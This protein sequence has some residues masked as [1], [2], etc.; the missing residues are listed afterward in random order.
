MQMNLL[1]TILEHR[2]SGRRVV[3]AGTDPGIVTT[4]TTIP[5]TLEEVFADINR[6]QVLSAEDNS[7]PET[8]PYPFDVKRLPKPS[9]ITAG[10]IDNA[11]FKKCHQK[12]HQR[13][14]ASGVSAE[15][16][17]K[18]L[19]KERREREIRA[20]R[21]YGK[22]TAQERRRIREHAQLPP[23]EQAPAVIH[24]FGHWQGV[25]SPIKG[26]SRRGTK[27]IREQHRIYGHVGLTNEYNTSKTCPY[28]FSK[29]VLHQ[30]RRIV[31]GKEQIVR[32]N[33]A[34]ECVHPQCPARTIGYTTRGR[35][36]NAAANIALSGASIVLAADHQPLPC[37]RQGSKQTRYTLATNL[38]YSHDTST[39]PRD[40]T[41]E[42]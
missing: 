20:K 21:A 6:F 10:L 31:N 4:S 22:I 33:G 40:S 2:S 15:L 25:N 14:Q 32:L 9:R 37:Y 7:N 13:R 19:A 28:C 41:R 16:Q 8:T 29:V 5:R 34:I 24:C 18:K 39:V 3:F 27:K 1:P 17:Q 42:E 36:A 35:D 30:A 12:R 38:S 26:H 11:T 23:G